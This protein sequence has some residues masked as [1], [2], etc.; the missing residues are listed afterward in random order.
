MKKSIL[1]TFFLFFCLTIMFGQT[2][3]IK[4]ADALFEEYFY[5]SASE[6]YKKIA[7][8]NPSE[9]VLERLGDSYY[10]NID[11]E[12]AAEAYALLFKNFTPDNPKFM[13]KYAQ[14]L[15]GIGRFDEFNLWMRKFRDISKGRPTGD[16]VTQKDAYSTASKKADPTFKV[17]NLRSI[18]SIYSDFGVTDFG[19]TILFSSPR[20]RAL[21]IEEKDSKEE[22]NF[23]DIFSVRKKNI[24]S[25]AEYLSSVR[26]LYAKGIKSDLNESSI[27]F[28]LDKKTM[29]FTRNNFVKK[30]FL[31][32]K[33][34]YNN[35][36]I[37]KAEWFNGRW[38]NVV[39]L[40]FSSDDYSVGHP[41]LSKDG[42]RLYFISDMPG[43]VG[44]TDIYAVNVYKDNVYGIVENLG[45]TINTEGREMFP[46]ISDDEV[47]YF[48][49]DGHIGLGDLDV[50][51]T[52]KEIDGYTNPINLKFPVNSRSDDFAFSMNP[53]TKKGYVSSN[54]KGSSGLDDI[55]EVEQIE[56]V[57]IQTVAGIL[58]EIQ[59]KKYLPEAKIIVKDELGTILKSIISDE[60]GLFSFELPCNQKFIITTSKEYYKE[61]TAYFETSEKTT[62]DL[63]LALEI[64]NDFEYDSRNE[65]IIKINTIYFD[66]NK[67]NIRSEAAIELDKIVSIMT[68]YPKIIV[69][70]ASHTDA[71]G[72]RAYNKILS[73]RRAKSA[74][75][76]IIYKGISPERI[77]GKGFGEDELTNKCVDN[78]AHSNRVKCSKLQ[79][80]EN[81]RTS[82]LVLNIDEIEAN[83]KPKK[84]FSRWE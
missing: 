14:S 38:D 84:T 3:E 15:R 23:L 19:N 49:S 35:L 82:F 2:K 21:S 63:D 55:Y 16:Y 56:S 28:S 34:G 45:P 25:E 31:T 24:S 48:S 39:E 76:Y 17:T 61:N 79:H 50:Y 32:V 33:K 53:V 80:Q 11:L 41:S 4:A 30:K 54:R 26:P 44:Q 40:P 58:R 74:V 81:R 64:E 13:F 8:T 69:A 71:K 37:F 60:N 29:Y 5:K 52:R 57:C 51:A 68:K 73:Q 70:S 12:E 59:F 42:S 20:G 1:V 77:Y 10:Y 72:N 67:W 46:F 6:V 27:T 75:D 18:N 62:L 47:L 36:K 66:S 78:D 65:L 9:H 22:N 7:Q 83:N 43:G